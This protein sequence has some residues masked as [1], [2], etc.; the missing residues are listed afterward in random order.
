MC[1]KWR[2]QQDGWSTHKGPARLKAAHRLRYRR[3][4]SGKSIVSRTCVLA[5]QE[6]REQAEVDAAYDIES[7]VVRQSLTASSWTS[8]LP[9]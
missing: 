9:H 5:V 8:K 3:L 1:L 2:L 7:T 6:G 4:G